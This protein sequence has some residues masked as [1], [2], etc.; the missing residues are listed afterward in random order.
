MTATFYHDKYDGRPMKGGGI[1]RQSNPHVAATGPRGYP[2]G[3]RLRLVNP[4]N[5]RVLEVEVRDRGNFSANNLDL[6]KAG[7]QQLGFT[8]YARL[9]VTIIK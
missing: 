6:S 5:G 9:H 2:I 7:Y 4:R 8:D 1:F 3:T